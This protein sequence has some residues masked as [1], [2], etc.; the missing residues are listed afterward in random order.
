M[1]TAQKT[2]VSL[3]LIITSCSQSANVQA[4]I[5][6]NKLCNTH[7]KQTNF[8]NLQSWTT[9][10]DKNKYVYH[11]TAA[12]DWCNG[13]LH[14]TQMSGSCQ[15]LVTLKSCLLKQSGATKKYWTFNLHTETC[16]TTH[17]MSLYS[18]T[19]TCLHSVTT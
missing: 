14:G 6:P 8:Y 12:N 16:Q 7:H 1:H 3:P 2:L 17:S 9:S 11:V 18:H 19:C 4:I 10:D 15:S 5:L 13:L